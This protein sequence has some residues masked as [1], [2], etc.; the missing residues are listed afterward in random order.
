MMLATNPPLS[1]SSP[2]CWKRSLVASFQAVPL[3]LEL[4]QRYPHVR[5]CK[6]QNI[7]YLWWL[8]DLFTFN[9]VHHI[10]RL[11]SPSWNIWD[12]IDTDKKDFRRCYNLRRPAQSAKRVG[13]N[14]WVTEDSPTELCIHAFLA[15]CGKCHCC[16][17]I[18]LRHK[19]K[20]LRGKITLIK[21]WRAARLCVVS[22]LG[23]NMSGLD[24]IR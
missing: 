22:I 24:H 2:C 13:A 3:R 17:N 8:C 21:I 5:L 23:N 14:R 16:H 10:G 1:P 9:S 19:S 15:N 11:H 18:F 6:R 20:S 7:Y 4:R 12:V